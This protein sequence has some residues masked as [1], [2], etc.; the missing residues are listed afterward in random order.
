[1]GNTFFIVG[2]TAWRSLAAPFLSQLVLDYGGRSTIS[3][4]LG[5]IHLDIMLSELIAVD[6]L[7][8]IS[9]P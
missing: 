7:K 6:D 8:R 2:R 9:V 4:I 1:M 3:P 5:L